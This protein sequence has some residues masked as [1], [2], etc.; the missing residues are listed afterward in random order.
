MLLIPKDLIDKY[1]RCKYVYYRER[2]K[3]NSDKSIDNVTSFEYNVY[4][5][6]PKYY[7][8]LIKVCDDIKYYIKKLLE[9]AINLEQTE[10][11]I[12]IEYKY[13]RL[14]IK[15]AY[16]HNG[17]QYY[18]SPILKATSILHI[19]MHLLFNESYENL[20]LLDVFIGMTDCFSISKI[21]D[22]TE[23]FHIIMWTCDSYRV[24]DIN[25]FAEYDTVLRDRYESVVIE[26][27][28]LQYSHDMQNFNNVTF[29]YPKSDTDKVIAKSCIEKTRLK[30]DVLLQLYKCDTISPIV[31][32]GSEYY[33]L[34]HA[35]QKF[36]TSHIMGK[37]HLETL[38]ENQVYITI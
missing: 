21:S 5:H 34:L 24:N 12:K 36:F 35:L 3:Y 7:Q 27:E 23:E 22:Y 15:Y 6:N 31:Q 4:L 16:D 32:D 9:L 37:I 14:G 10:N 30:K 18:E 28:S 13:Y 1:F 19:Y 25:M 2:Q 33:D 20:K 38:S 29:K 8:E 26:L 11:Q 17:M